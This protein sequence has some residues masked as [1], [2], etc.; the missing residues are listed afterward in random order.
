MVST[1][2]PRLNSLRRLDAQHFLQAPLE[3]AA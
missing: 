3:S 1:P 2:P